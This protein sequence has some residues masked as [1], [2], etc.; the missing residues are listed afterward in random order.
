[1]SERELK[2]LIQTIERQLG[3][4]WAEIVEWLR[5][6]N[7]IEVIE[8]RLAAR[9]VPIAK[10]EEAALQFAAEVN[11]AY[12]HA[13]RSGAAWLD[14]QAS[15]EGRAV[16]FDLA[17]PHAVAYAQQNRYELVREIVDE[18]R[19][20]IH[21]VMAAGRQRGVNPREMARD[22]RDSIGLTSSQE[23]AVRSYRRSLE[24]G[25]WS[26][27]LR[28]E[29]RDGR[30]D[31]MLRGLRDGDGTVTGE[32]IDTLVERYRRNY[33]AY[34][35]ETI[36]RTESSRNTHA[37]LN[38]SFRQ[39]IDRGDLHARELVHEWLAGPRTRNS[40]PEHHDMNGTR[41]R[42]GEAFVFP[43]GVRK[44]YPCDG[45]GGAAHDA[46]CRCTVTTTLN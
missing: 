14:A 38:E 39:A 29:L 31:R 30:S 3:V 42:F 2:D 1:V 21:D 28:R 9:G 16:R 17:S 5:Q 40:R 13:G 6:Q 44:M 7:P 10:V 4:S 15:L 26:D 43:D 32:Q 12:A 35:A 27:A 11:A 34:R 20:T 8:E 23:E 41:V 33:V 19:G 37:G 36:A 45:N 46:N 24:T 18:Q 22:L 25:D